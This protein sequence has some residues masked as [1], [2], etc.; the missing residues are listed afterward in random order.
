MLW[1]AF[2]V[3]IFIDNVTEWQI[4]AVKKHATKLEEEEI[5]HVALTPAE[6]DDQK[7]LWKQ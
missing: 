3:G 1:A 2:G 6:K 7:R 5:E 4:E